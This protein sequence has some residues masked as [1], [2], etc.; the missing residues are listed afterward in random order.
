[1][2][3]LCCTN[4]LSAHPMRQL[5]IATLTQKFQETSTDMCLE[6]FAS[7]VFRKKCISWT[8]KLKNM[9][10]F[11]PGHSSYFAFLVQN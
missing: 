2:L 5:N 8:I 10:L 3:I 4:R 7:L 11:V 9:N 1:M 6:S